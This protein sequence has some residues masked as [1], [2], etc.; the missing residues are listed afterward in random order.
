MRRRALLSAT[1]VSATLA[2]RPVFAQRFPDRPIRVIV[3]FAA[4]GASDIVVRLMQPRLEAELSVPIVVVNRPGAGGVIGNTA[5]KDAPPDGLTMLSTHI[6]MEINRAMGRAA[7]GHEAFVPLGQTGQVDF[8][9]AV[10]PDSRYRTLENLVAA[11]RAAPQGVSHATNV[12]SVAHL[13]AVAFQD[14]VGAEFLVVPAGGGGDRKP[15]LLGGHVDSALFGVSE[16]LGEV[17]DGRIRVLATFGEQRSA[18][19]PEVPTAEESGFRFQGFPVAYWWMVPL[20]TPRDRV[21]VLER[22]IKQSFDDQ[23]IHR[24]F[25]DMGFAT[26]Y[27]DGVQV[28]ERARTGGAAVTEFV[29]RYKI[30]AT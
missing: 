23:A 22:A 21:A 8:V 2:A 14:A 17:R 26:R 30:S 1:A 27:L 20:A 13:A 18:R 12:A 5:A 15:L 16:I 24:R 6:G 7:F 29:R 11:M 28:R 4:G 9:I 19:L 25:E 3:P 10:P